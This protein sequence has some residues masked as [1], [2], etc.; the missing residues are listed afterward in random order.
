MYGDMHASSLQVADQKAVSKPG[1]DQGDDFVTRDQQLKFKQTKKDKGKRGNKGKG[2]KGKGKK[3]KNGKGP[4][5][6]KSRK[7]QILSAG[8]QPDNVAKK[9]KKEKIQA[10]EVEVDDSEVG[11]ASV[12]K[13]SKPGK[14]KLPKAKAKAKAKTG[15]QPC[16]KTPTAKAKAKATAA[17]APKR[18]PRGKAARLPGSELMSNPLRKNSLV[19]SLMDFAEKFPASL[20]DKDKELKAAVLAEC[21]PLQWCKLMPYWSRNGCGV[22]VM[23]DD[24]KTYYD[25]HHFSFQSSSAPR[26]YKLAIAVRCA[27]IAVT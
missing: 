15:K 22:K 4:L 17:P 25:L 13:P 24:G 12:S 21:S 8:S 10:P 3:G 6:K 11:T 16:T 14:A 9:S 2:K 18:K 19:K 7:R 26:R 27:E 5:P 20:E 1:D 23:N